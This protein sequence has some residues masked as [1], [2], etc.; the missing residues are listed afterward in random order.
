MEQSTIVNFGKHNGKTLQQ[1][2][3]ED[4]N[5]VIWL[6][7]NYD[8]YA[9]SSPNRYAKLK[10]ETINYRTSLKNE[11]KTLSELHFNAL[12][13]KNREET[14]STHFGKLGLRLTFEVTIKNIVQK[15]DYS[16]V[17][18]DCQGNHVYFYDKGFNLTPGQRIKLT[19]TIYKQI[20]NLGIPVTY[21]NRVKI[22]NLQNQ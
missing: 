11:A 7:K 14:R 4:I 15:Y 13:E 2:A 18:T 5:W 8:V 22:E 16:V 20:E 17:K 10:Q 9:F 3:T 6:S 21:M 12:A 19:G 1:I